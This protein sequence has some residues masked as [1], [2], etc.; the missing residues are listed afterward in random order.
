[1]FH[2]CLTQVLEASKRKQ[3][4][5]IDLGTSVPEKVWEKLHLVA[6]LLGEMSQIFT[7]QEP[8]AGVT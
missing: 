5:N 2:T 4:I 6:D 7:D 8:L 3:W 1:M